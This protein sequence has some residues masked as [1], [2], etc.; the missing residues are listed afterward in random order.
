MK[1]TDEQKVARKAERQARL[2]KE[3]EEREIAHAA[4]QAAAADAYRKRWSNRRLVVFNRGV[5]DSP[6]FE[7]H[8]RAKNW[9]ATV[10]PDPTYPGGFRRLWWERGR[11]EFRYIVPEQLKLG[12]VVEFG[13]DYVQWSGRKIPERWLGV[14]VERTDTAVEFKPVHDMSE[15]VSVVLAAANGGV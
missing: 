7:H 11:G 4:R 1:L 6:V 5:L 15:A 9:A 12:D 3:N 2:L 10:T 14:V 13:A 8:S